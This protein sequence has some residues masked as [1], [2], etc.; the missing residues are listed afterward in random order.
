MVERENLISQWLMENKKV[1]EKR[2]K[3]S[4]EKK[5]R[6]NVKKKREK[7]VPIDKSKLSTKELASL[8]QKENKKRTTRSERIMEQLLNKFKISNEK[9]KIFFYG[10]KEEYFYLADF[11]LPDL[12]IVIEVDGKYHNTPEQQKRD[13]Y[14]DEHYTKTLKL[15]LLR[16]TNEKLSSTRHK[17]LKTLI[18]QLSNDSPAGSSVYLK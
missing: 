17:A 18:L 1:V 4:K 9:Q 3:S 13:F 2:K 16:I 15:K 11:Y 6:V 10:E 5:K 7:K 8:Y 14:K 12:G